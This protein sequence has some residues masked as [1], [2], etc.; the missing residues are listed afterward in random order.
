MGSITK[1]R[2][3]VDFGVGCGLEVNLHSASCATL[4]K[5]VNFSVPHFLSLV[6]MDMINN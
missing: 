4:R 6:N 2:K 5:L 1:K 3:S